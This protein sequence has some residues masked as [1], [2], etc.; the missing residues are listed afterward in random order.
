[1]M[2]HIFREFADRAISPFGYEDP[3]GEDEPEDDED[4][5]LSSC[6]PV[7]V[8]VLMTDNLTFEP[9]EIKVEV[10]R[11]IRLTIENAGQQP[12]D[13]TIE[14]IWI[15]V[16]AGTRASDQDGFDLHLALDPGEVSTLAF[17][18]QKAGWYAFHC[19]IGDHPDDEMT[20]TLV[21]V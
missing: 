9:V 2:E 8:T 6:D 13:F 7:E 10:D 11:P 20:G 14:E 21:V 15:V 1:M 12:H 16:E 4:Y 3:D 18:P 19:T 17:T 5:P